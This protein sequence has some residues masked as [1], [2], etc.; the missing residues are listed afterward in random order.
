MLTIKIKLNKAKDGLVFSWVA[1]KKGA[2]V[3]S[4]DTTSNQPDERT[5]AGAQKSTGRSSDT[6]SGAELGSSSEA[7]ASASGK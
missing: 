3:A 5:I 7:P 2:K 6:S 4:K 1:P